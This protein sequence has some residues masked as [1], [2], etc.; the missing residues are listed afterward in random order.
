[1]ARKG[2]L[3][4][5]PQVGSIVPDDRYPGMWRVVAR[6]RVFFRIIFLRFI[7]LR[8]KLW[9]REFIRIFD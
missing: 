5:T 4:G 1:M 8:L 2:S 7:R 6:F 3:L 9:M